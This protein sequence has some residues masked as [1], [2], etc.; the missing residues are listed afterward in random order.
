MLLTVTR[1]FRISVSDA[2]PFVVIKL[3]V[4][5]LIFN[6]N[7][8]KKTAVTMTILSPATTAGLAEFPEIT[9]APVPKQFDVV[10]QIDPP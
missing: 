8:I 5:P 3:T 9:T 1:L 2:L 4:I 7:Y 6:N 10:A